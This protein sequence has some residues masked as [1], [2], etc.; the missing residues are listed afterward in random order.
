MID[1]F[2]IWSHPRHDIKV[3]SFEGIDL[4]YFDYDV[5]FK[6]KL[7]FVRYQIVT[8]KPNPFIYINYEQP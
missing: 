7:E 2:N 8:G 4:L 6:M 1:P 5:K 3:N